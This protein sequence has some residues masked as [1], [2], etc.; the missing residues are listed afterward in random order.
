M[1]TIIKLINL[2]TDWQIIGAQFTKLENIY[3]INLRKLYYTHNLQ[4]S[5]AKIHL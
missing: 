3:N 1:L 2:I 4:I 5:G